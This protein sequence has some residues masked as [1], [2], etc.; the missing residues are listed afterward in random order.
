MAFQRS[1][2]I[3]FSQLASV[4]ELEAH[5][6]QMIRTLPGLRGQLLAISMTEVLERFAS[7]KKHTTSRYTLILISATGE[8]VLEQ[9]PRTADL[10]SRVCDAVQTTI[11]AYAR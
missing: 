2:G 8:V 11:G 10:E 6:D 9:I 3:D 7:D 5:L 1:L 4:L